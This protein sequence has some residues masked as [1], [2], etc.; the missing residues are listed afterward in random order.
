[1]ARLEI[2]FLGAFQVS[3][4]GEPVTRFETAPARALLIY[5]AMHPGMPF[6]REVLADLLWQD[7]GRSEA[8]HALRQTLNRLRRAIKD[9][10]NEQAF[11]QITRQTIQFNPESDYW[12]DTEVFSKLYSSRQEHP[13]RRLDACAPCMQ[14]LAQAL[15]VLNQQQR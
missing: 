2:A 1:M 14:R 11:L 13:H 8:L 12:L 10:K 5:L 4:D 9:T 7:Q 15:I 6:R 3:R